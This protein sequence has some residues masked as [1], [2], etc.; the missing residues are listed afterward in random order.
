MCIRDF[1]ITNVIPWFGGM[2]ASIVAL[3][4]I[5]QVFTYPSKDERMAS[6]GYVEV[7]IIND[8]RTMVFMW[9][10]TN[11]TEYEYYLRSITEKSK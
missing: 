1:M 5:W 3:V 10:P 9:V 7:P 8:G 4:F 2:I 11:S 6:K